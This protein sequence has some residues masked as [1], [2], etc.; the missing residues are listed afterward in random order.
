MNVMPP[1]HTSHCDKL[2]TLLENPNRS[3]QTAVIR[4][5]DSGGSWT[6]GQLSVELGLV[7]GNVQLDLCEL[8][9]H[10]RNPGVN[11]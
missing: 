6:L 5:G 3:L 9:S 11:K 2:S 10:D 1:E 4:L 7:Q 8:A